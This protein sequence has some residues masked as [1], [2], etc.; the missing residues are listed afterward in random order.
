MERIEFTTHLQYKSIYYNGSFMRLSSIN[1]IILDV[2]YILEHH[3]LF[4]WGKL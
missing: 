2:V 4:I 3:K 1:L